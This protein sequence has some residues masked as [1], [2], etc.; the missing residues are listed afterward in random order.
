M[1]THDW[2]RPR[3]TTRLC[4]RCGL[5]EHWEIGKGWVVQSAGVGGLCVPPATPPPPPQLPPP[6]ATW[7][8]PRRV[9]EWWWLDLNE[10]SAPGVLKRCGRVSWNADGTGH[11]RISLSYEGDD[12]LD[13]RH[14]SPPV[15]ELSRRAPTHPRQGGD[16]AVVYTMAPEAMLLYGLNLTKLFANEVVGLHHFYSNSKL[17]NKIWQPSARGCQYGCNRMQ[18]NIARFSQELLQKRLDDEYRRELEDI[19]ATSGDE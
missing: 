10:W 18:S 19:L 2:V 6:P 14:A 16:S 3:P 12:D 17:G 5:H 8:E 7:G 11:Y 4:R 13:E 1:T 9:D 15:P